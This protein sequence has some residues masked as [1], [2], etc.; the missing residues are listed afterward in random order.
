MRYFSL[1]LKSNPTQK[2]PITVGKIIASGGAGEICV[3][4]DQPDTVLKLY[5]NKNDLALYEQKLGAMLASPPLLKP[6]DVG[7]V[8][9]PQ[10]TW[11][12]ALVV[13]END[14]FVGYQMP[15]MDLT[16]SVSLERFLQRRMRQYEGLPEFYAHRINVAYN[17]SA[18]IEALNH[19][20]HFVVDLKPQNCFLHRTQLF[21]TMLDCD[22]FKIT[23]EDG[24]VYP[25]YQFSEEYIAPEFIKKSPQELGEEQD[26]FALAVIIFKLLN[27]GVHP[28][29]AG[30]KR[31]QKTIQQMVAEKKYAYGLSGSGVLIPHNQSMHEYFPLP[32]RE[33]FD[34]AFGSK[35][36][37]PSASEWRQILFDLQ[38]SENND[39]KRC[40]QNP[41]EHLD[42]GLGCG[43]CA[44]DEGR[45]IPKTV[46][47]STASVVKKTNNSLRF[48]TKRL[49]QSKPVMPKYQNKKTN[50]K[51]KDQLYQLNMMELSS[52]I[53]RSKNI[54]KYYWILI[55]LII[56]NYFAVVYLGHF[57]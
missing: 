48:P 29:Q 3:C 41:T 38:S 40:D 8:E 26:R 56:A 2:K 33:A 28:F 18:L 19:K 52:I 43:Q 10:L 15:K 16:N 6:L 30:M 45:I 5:K 12:L 9:F 11:P 14:A 23:A 25:A 13:D 42:L 53:K 36:N 55:I 34:R 46:K 32:L 31:A 49:L 54:Y 4:E 47:R 1:D 57:I 20:G 24:Q 39:V 37:L 35:N 17:L 50:I 44:V 7:G 22:G 27:N 21:L 51:T